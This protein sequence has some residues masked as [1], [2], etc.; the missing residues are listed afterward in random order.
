MS[1]QKIFQTNPFFFF[2]RNK[3][4]SILPNTQN[5]ISIYLSQL[6]HFLYYISIFKNSKKFKV[7]ISIPSSINISITFKI[8]NSKS[9]ISHEKSKK[10]REY[11]VSKNF[12]NERNRSFFFFLRN[13]MISILANTQ[14]Q[15]FI[16]LSQLLHFLYYISSFKNSK[17]LKYQSLFHLR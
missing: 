7:S 15:I 17:S 1:Y 16:Y 8:L 3:M 10:G 5:Q 11:I 14:N 13:R 4:I 9:S 6:L 12:P 2:L